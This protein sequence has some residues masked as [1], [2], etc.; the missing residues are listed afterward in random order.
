MTHEEYV[1]ATED[2]SFNRELARDKAWLKYHDARSKIDRAYDK[3]M[4][5]LWD[6]LWVNKKKEGAEC[7]FSL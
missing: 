4:E 7:P 2:L 6:E 1:K 5:K 3:A